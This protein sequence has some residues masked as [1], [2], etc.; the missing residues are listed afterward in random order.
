MEMEYYI[1]SLFAATLG[2]HGLALAVVHLQR[3][4]AFEPV[5]CE[6]LV[7]RLGYGVE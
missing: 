7:D 6:N 2:V 1:L 3:F 4:K 5:T